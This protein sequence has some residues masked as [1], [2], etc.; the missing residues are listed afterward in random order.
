MDISTWLEALKIPAVIGAMVALYFAPQK[1]G[2][3]IGESHSFA[4]PNYQ[5]GGIDQVTLTNLKDRSTPIFELYA[6]HGDVAIRLIKFHNPLV[7]KSFD[8]VQVQIPKVSEYLVDDKPYDFSPVGDRYQDAEIYY[9]TIGGW[10]RC[11]SLGRPS[12]D[13][14]K[15]ARKELFRKQ[16]LRHASIVMSEHN[17]VV[18]SPRVVYI[19]AYKFDGK[20]EDAFIDV[21]GQISWK[22][23]ERI[24]PSL[25]KDVQLVADTLLNH[26][27]FVE[28]I[29]IKK[30][31]GW[32]RHF[33]DGA[34]FRRGED[35]AKVR[36]RR[37]P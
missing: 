9:S 24:D 27:P 4:R 6:V 1:L 37:P 21:W 17:G 19:L 14:N 7:L 11:V 26:M 8:S 20:W 36:G 16:S 15:L 5:A 2:Y 32:N 33:A 23:Q 31:V 22:F 18:Y 28:S 25:L 3:K 30:T 13:L 10:K 29:I 34:H 12:V 35:D